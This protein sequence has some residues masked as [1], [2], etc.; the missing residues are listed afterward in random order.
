MNVCPSTLFQVDVESEIE[1]WNRYK[2]NIGFY[3]LKHN[4][5]EIA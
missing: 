5:F 1:T 2:A 4:I 3:R